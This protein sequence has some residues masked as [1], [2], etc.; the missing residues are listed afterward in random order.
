M[1][2]RTIRCKLQIEDE[3]AAAFLQTQQAF[4]QACNAILQVA[5]DAKV[6]HPIQLHRLVYAKIREQFKLSANLTVRAIRRVAAGL[7]QKKKKQKPLPKQFRNASIEYDARVFTFWEKGFR[8]S[9]S[10][11]EGRKKAFLCIGNYQ[12]KALT[13]KKPTSATLIRK[14][15]AWHLNIVIE[16]EEP[17]PKDGPAIGIDLGL[18]NIAYS[19]TG[20]F[21]DGKRR[22]DFKKQRAKIRASLQSK[23][24]RGSYKKLKQLSG[25]EKRKIRHHNHELSK[26]LV[27]DAVKAQ[28]G[29]IRMERLTHIRK[30][31]LVWNPHRN[32]SM[33]GWSFSH[34]QQFVEYKAKR[35]GIAVEY[36]NPAYTSQV[37][38]T[39]GQKGLRVGQVF[40][41][42]ACGTH[43]A[44]YNAACLISVGRAEV[45]RPGLTVCT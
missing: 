21:L 29:L 14:G 30:K 43:H 23:A 40:K 24:T 22:Q 36:V 1:L 9:L 28:A 13:G 2:K 37:C 5:L 41:C 27:Q 3:A 38:F 45:S 26:Q 16:E 11:L 20:F 33:A 15:K 10:T 12:K 25:Y 18:T 31:T 7:S 42:R 44:D 8:V 32:R 4:G 19:S 34:L 6:G 39:S 35:A 17:P